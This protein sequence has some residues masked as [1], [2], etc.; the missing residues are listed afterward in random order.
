VLTIER[1]IAAD[2]PMTAAVL[3]ALD[4]P[5]ALLANS[6]GDDTSGIESK[7]GCSATA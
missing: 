1:S 5:T 3:A 4:V 6:T 2:A 7:G